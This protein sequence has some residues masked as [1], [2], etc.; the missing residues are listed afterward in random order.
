MVELNN[1]HYL[2]AR[3][4]PTKWVIGEGEKV[5]PDSILPA[6]ASSV[7][8]HQNAPAVAKKQIKVFIYFYF[9]VN[10]FN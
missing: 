9:N 5:P 6:S 8:L 2:R 3:T 7:E 4:Q 10:Y 1:Q